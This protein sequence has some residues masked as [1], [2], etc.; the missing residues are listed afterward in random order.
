MPDPAP[1]FAVHLEPSAGAAGQPLRVLNRVLGERTGQSATL[2]AARD[3]R[4]ILGIRPGIGVEGFTL[5]D[6]PTPGAIRILGNDPTGLLHGLGKFLHDARY[7]PGKLTPGAWRGTSVPTAAIRGMYFAFNFNNWYVSCP[8]EEFARYAQDLVLWGFNSAIIS[9]LGVNPSDQAA[10]AARV[11]DNRAVLI[12]LKE[13]GLKVGVLMCANFG[14]PNPPADGLAVDVPDANPARRGNCEGRA[15]PS[16][17]AGRAFIRRSYEQLLAGYED[18]GLDFACTFPYDAGGCG[19]EACRPW[20]AKGYVT[21]SKDFSEIAKAR[22]PGLRFIVPTWCFDVLEQSEGEYEGL[23]RE[24]RRDPKWVDY[25]MA[26]SHYDF[27]PYVLE[28]G[29]PGGLPLLNFPEISMWGRFPWGGY[30][31]NPLPGRYQRLWD[32][33]KH[34]CKGG[35]PYS[36]GI[37]EDI[38]KVFYGRFYW[39]PNASAAQTLREYIAYEFSP[40]VVDDV[41]AAV[42]LL[43]RNWERAN[44]TVDVAAKAWALLQRADAKLPAYTR[45]AW[46]WR[47]LYL[48]GLI[49]FEMMSNPDQPHSDRCDEALEELTSIY[50]AENTGGPDAPRSRRCIERLR[51]VAEQ[52][53]PGSA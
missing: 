41:V 53:P 27:P 43:E 4:L 50:H 18:I 16:K 31:A 25:I 22:Y 1:P 10:F 33:V 36:E 42:E 14:F 3:A 40:D 6:G 24:I 11:R 37:F 26:D 45:T 48:R 7:A 19:C 46:R 8:R 39:D 13:A 29:A 20:G 17:P 28:H 47:I 32:Q 21:A 9:L 49:D 5:E 35:F 34:L 38:N 30:G 52:R 23:D 51:R 44:A 12:A 15:C 2:A